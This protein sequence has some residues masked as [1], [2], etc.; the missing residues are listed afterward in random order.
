MRYSDSVIVLDRNGNITRQCTPEELSG[1][2]L[3]LERLDDDKSTTGEPALDLELP[4]EILEH[5]ATTEVDVGG[6]RRVGDAKIY[7]YFIAVAGWWYMVLYVIL[8]SA[9]VFGLRFP[10]ESSTLLANTRSPQN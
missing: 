4:D 10:C 8:Y 3:D 9:F 5:M 1:V 2:T 6:D 7:A